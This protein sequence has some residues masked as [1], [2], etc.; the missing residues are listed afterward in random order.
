MA[1]SAPGLV[2][3]GD[4]L[5]LLASVLPRPLHYPGHRALT[6]LRLLLDLVEHRLGKIEALLSLV[7]FR[8]IVGAA[9]G[10]GHDSWRLLSHGRGPSAQGI[11]GRGA[12]GS[13]DLGPRNGA[14]Q[15]PGTQA[16][17]NPRCYGKSQ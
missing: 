4:R 2:R 14:G 13:R 6:S 1:D 3:T 5:D 15:A 10:V 12:W 11:D 8:C 9:L 16:R 17:P 7:A